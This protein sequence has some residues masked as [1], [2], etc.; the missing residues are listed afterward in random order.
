MEPTAPSQEDSGAQAPASY[1]QRTAWPRAL[2][3]ISLVPW[4]T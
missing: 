1:P 3:D 2:P 4:F